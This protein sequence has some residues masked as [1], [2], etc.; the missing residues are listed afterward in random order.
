MTVQLPVLLRATVAEETPF[1][2]DWLAME[3]G[4]VVLKLTCNRFGLPVD[5]AVA[6]TVGCGPEIRTGLGKGP[7]VMVWSFL[8]TAGGEGGLWRDVGSIVTGA[9]VVVIV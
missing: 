9:R 7:S 5:M 3:Q 1:V 8:S 2:I 6:V 4:P